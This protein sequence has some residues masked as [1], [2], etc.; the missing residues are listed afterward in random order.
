M[1]KSRNIGRHISAVGVTSVTSDREDIP[2]G[3]IVWTAIREA[4]LRTYPVD[5]VD[6]RR[7]L[8]TIA[9]ATQGETQEAEDGSQNDDHSVSNAQENGL[10]VVQTVL[11]LGDLNVSKTPDAVLV[12]VDAVG[13]R[14][15]HLRLNSESGGQKDERQGGE[16]T[17][18]FQGRDGE[19]KERP[20]ARSRL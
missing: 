10:K 1:D 4:E 9:Q 19:W 7:T 15:D 5:Q 3:T 13:L 16:K 17:A 11:L 12:V 14:L 20:R 18:K 2:Y 8:V 6:G